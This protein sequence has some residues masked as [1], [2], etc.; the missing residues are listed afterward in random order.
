[1]NCRPLLPTFLTIAALGVSGPCII[2]APTMFLSTLACATGMT[3]LSGPSLLGYVAMA[4]R[5]N[6]L[7]NYQMEL[8]GVTGAMQRATTPTTL[9]SFISCVMPFGPDLVPTFQL[10]VLCTIWQIDLAYQLSHTTKPLLLALAVMNNLASGFA[11]CYRLASGY[12]AD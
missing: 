12:V 1:M 11:V 7:V 3:P 6:W 9:S 2:L 8:L 5:T 10:K 4:T